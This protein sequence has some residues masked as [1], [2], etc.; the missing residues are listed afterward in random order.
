MG[1]CQ[2]PQHSKTPA[3]MEI[4]N[5]VNQRIQE[6]Q[7]T[8]LYTTSPEETPACCYPEEKNST[9][10]LDSQSRVVMNSFYNQTPAGNWK[11]ISL[12][13]TM[14]TRKSPTALKIERKGTSSTAHRTLY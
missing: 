8:L 6:G 3:G 7:K 4:R 10:P 9:L 5:L 1:E 12:W 14:C 11:N 13:D 2:C